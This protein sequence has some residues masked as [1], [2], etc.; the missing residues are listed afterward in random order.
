MTSLI[1][2]ALQ[3]S[4]RV[5]SKDKIFC[6]NVDESKLTNYLFIRLVAKG[7][8]FTNVDF[9]YSI[10]DT[11]Y[12]RNCHFDSCDFTG[13][14]FIGTNLT[15]SSFAGCKFDYVNFERTLVENDILYYPQGALAMKI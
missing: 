8:K 13:C 4:A 3:D 10:F 6:A 1:N 9:K 12:L 15:G 2:Q 7:K 11:C 14:R 5:E